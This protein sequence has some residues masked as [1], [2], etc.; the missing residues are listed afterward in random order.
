VIQGIQVIQGEQ[1]PAGPDKELQVR[2]VF[3]DLKEIPRDSVGT[4]TA[5]CAPDEVATGGGYYYTSDQFSNGLN[6]LQ[7]DFGSPDIQPNQW[8]FGLS[9]S[10]TMI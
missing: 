9:P 7:N 6:P 1:G 8:E 5:S 10:I 3:G 4:A 2:T